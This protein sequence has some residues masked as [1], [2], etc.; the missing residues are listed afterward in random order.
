[1]FADPLKV[2]RGCDVKISDSITLHQPTI[3]EIEKHGELLFFSVF[4]TICAIPSDFKSEL[5]DKGVDWTVVDDFDLFIM[6]SRFYPIEKTSIIIPG[7]DFS[8]LEPMMSSDNQLLLA[9]KD[10]SVII[11]RNDYILMIEYIREFLGIRPKAEKKV[12]DRYTKMALLNDDR[13]LKKKQEGKP[14]KPFLLPMIVTLVNTEEFSYDYSTVFNLT[15]NQLT[16]SYIQI[17]KKKQ[18]IALM[19]GS[20][21]GFIDTSKIKS[22]DLNWCYEEKTL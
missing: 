16:K 11:T 21:S 22:T 13:R 18:S 12:H 9:S 8:T 6:L 4:S 20:F 2:L 5:W 17:Q 14:Y 3:G 10:A 15:I 7:I 1:M 19:Q